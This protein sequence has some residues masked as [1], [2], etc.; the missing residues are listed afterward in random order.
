MGLTSVF[1][2][3][4]LLLRKEMLLFSLE[5]PWLLFQ[6]CGDEMAW[7]FFI[8]VQCLTKTRHVSG[9]S[10]RI[11]LFHLC[12]KRWSNHL[13]AVTLGPSLFVDPK[14]ISDEVKSRHPTLV[15]RRRGVWHRDWETQVSVSI[16][17]TAGESAVTKQALVIAWEYTTEKQ[18]SIKPSIGNCKLWIF[19]HTLTLEFANI[20]FLLW[21]R[22]GEV[23][24]VWDKWCTGVGGSLC[25]KYALVVCFNNTAHLFPWYSG[26]FLL[27][28]SLL[29]FKNTHHLPWIC[30]HIS[31]ALTKTPST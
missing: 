9:C 10:V 8:L 16:A 5:F 7:W 28:H 22:V 21:R 19:F 14:W 30:L 2:G 3:F 24:P 26:S 4:C 27:L 29:F 25:V 23:F 13:T 12:Q 18:I 31:R 6:S 11:W 20:A 15:L 17:G 1:V